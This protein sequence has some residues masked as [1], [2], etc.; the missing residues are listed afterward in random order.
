MLELRSLAAVRAGRWVFRGLNAVV[1]AGSTL[2]LRGPNGSG[3]TT[4]LRVLAGLMGAE[5]GSVWWAGQAVSA[6]APSEA[7]AAFRQQLSWVGH[8]AGLKPD[9]NSQENL[10]SIE[11]LRAEAVSSNQVSAAL[12]E[13]GLGQAEHRPACC[14]GCVVAAPSG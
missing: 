4:L 1:P 3:K 6:P 5:R 2:H 8:V 10:T 7:V 14:P 11:S 9:L 13:M 12:E